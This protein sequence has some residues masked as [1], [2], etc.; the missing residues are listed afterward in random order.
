MP[1]LQV[2]VITKDIVSALVEVGRPPTNPDWFQQQLA[3]HRVKPRCAA[4]PTAAQQAMLLP[5]GPENVQLHPAGQMPLLHSY[6]DAGAW[7]AAVGLA[8]CRQPALAPYSLLIVCPCTTHRQGRRPRGPGQQ[9][10]Q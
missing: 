9:G 2:C 1:R 7:S 3:A 10:L 6:S 8:A 5:D 4:L